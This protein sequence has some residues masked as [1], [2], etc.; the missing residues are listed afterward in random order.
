MPESPEKRVTGPVT[1]T[2][3]SNG[4]KVPDDIA[5]D[6]ILVEKAVN[7]IPIAQLEFGDGDLPNQKWPVSDSD[8]FEP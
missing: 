5:I 8:L 2:V 1:V 6:K 7:M 4:S 3:Y